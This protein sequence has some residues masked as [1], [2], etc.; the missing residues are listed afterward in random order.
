MKDRAAARASIERIL[1][2]DFDR[3]VI[4]HGEVTERDGK[5]Q[6]QQAFAWLLR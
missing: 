6:F 4:S 3:I 1:E 5:R 2:W